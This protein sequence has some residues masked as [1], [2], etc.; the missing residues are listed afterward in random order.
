MDTTQQ[1]VA[2][3]AALS[4]GDRCWFW[5]SADAPRTPLMLER[6]SDPSG[7]AKLLKQASAQHLPM[8]A[9]T[10]TGIAAVAGDGTVQF[11]S[12]VFSQG[13]LQSLAQWVQ[14][15]VEAHPELAY[16]SGAQFLQ[17]SSSGEV[18]ERFEKGH[19]TLRGIVISD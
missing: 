10:C 5:F 17:V 6:F 12:S 4:A 8:G 13:M 2:Q 16:L 7:M 11:G 3:L 15:N 14:S 18:G 9:T 1:L 19:R